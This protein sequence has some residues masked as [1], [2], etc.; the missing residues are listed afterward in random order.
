MASLF[1]WSMFLTV[2]NK[3]IYLPAHEQT[4]THPR[5]YTKT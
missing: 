2:Q 4:F 1:L 5:M 3:L